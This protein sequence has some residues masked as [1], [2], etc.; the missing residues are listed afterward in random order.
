[1]EELQLP[2][3]LVIIMDGNRRFAKALGKDVTEG[4]AQG[5]DKIE[6]VLS[7]L[8]ELGIKQVT[9]WAWSTENFDRPKEEVDFIMKLGEKFANKI[10]TDE[11]IHKNRIRFRAIGDIKLFPESLQSAL[12]R[13][14]DAT[15]AYDNLFLNLALCYGGRQEIIDA[16]K[17]LAKQIE[18]GKIK[19]EQI[20]PELLETFMYSREVPNVDLIIRTSGEQRTSGFLMWKSDYAEFYFSEKY[21]PEFDKAELMRALISY[22]ERRRRFGK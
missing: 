10:E 12:R 9:L 6:E 16:I 3:H 15:K 11:R 20:T 5:A 14:M 13:A 22:S 21:W 19:A 18:A 7:W 17:D 1:M 8:Q 4:H 2:K